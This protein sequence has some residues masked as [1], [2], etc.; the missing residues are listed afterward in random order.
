MQS[1]TKQL[2]IQKVIIKYCSGLVLVLSA[3][4]L[5]AACGEATITPGSANPTQTTG[6]AASAPN[7]TVI[8]NN[9]NQI[10]TEIRNRATGVQP[11]LLPARLP[12]GME[13]SLVGAN[14]NSFSVQYTDLK[15][16]KKV[17]LATVIPN[18]PL[19][20]DK[21]D[22]TKPQFRDTTALYQ[23]KDR[24]Q[25]TGLR[26][27]IWDE[28]GK[29]ASDSG[30]RDRVSYYLTAEGLT[31]GEFWQLANS[32]GTRPENGKVDAAPHDNLL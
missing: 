14:Q 22:Q 8:S 4:L 23:V 26:F 31:E 29:W 1:N 15:A 24:T 5:L 10:A 17:L 6:I 13:A 12:A 3:M 20:G 21:T 27:L 30:L 2:L 32:L 25:P 19:P 7:T 18:P 9:T 28:P 11:V 16:G